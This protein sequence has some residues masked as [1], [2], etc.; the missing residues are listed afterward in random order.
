MNDS[1][2][3]SGRMMQANRTATNSAP[4]LDR[5]G[6]LA[7]M[8]GDSWLLAEMI[9]I[10]FEDG[11]LLLAE[12]SAA[13]SAGDFASARMKSHAIRGL[14][15]GCGGMAAAQAAERVEKAADAGD[16]ASLPHLVATLS[17][18][19]TRLRRAATA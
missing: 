13:A 6:A 12:L 5:E 9:E 18:E 16:R 17:A 4:V 14:V 2:N 10:V 15:A 8:G 11:S 1:K 19:F 3:A 7:R